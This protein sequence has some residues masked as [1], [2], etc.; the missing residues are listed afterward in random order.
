MDGVDNQVAHACGRLS[1]AL[2][3]VRMDYHK[4]SPQREIVFTPVLVDVRR[5]LVASVGSDFE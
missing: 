5:S 1:G 2:H 3:I 4:A